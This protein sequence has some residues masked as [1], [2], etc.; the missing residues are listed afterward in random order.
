MFAITPQPASMNL[1]HARA[2]LQI[3][4]KQNAVGRLDI[5]IP[6]QG[7]HSV[8]VFSINGQSVFSRIG[9]GACYYEIPRDQISSG[10]YLVRIA[11]PFHNVMKKIL[12]K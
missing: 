7:L 8:E 10:P 5:S 4:I 11:T 9:F 3:L 1:K 12:I 6:D 2:A